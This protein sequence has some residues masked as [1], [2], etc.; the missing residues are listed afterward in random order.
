[1]ALLEKKAKAVQM[2]RDGASYSQIKDALG[3]SKSTLS[4]WLAGMPLPEARLRELRDFNAVRIERYRE[5]RRRTRDARRS[6]V[7][8]VAKREIGALSKR[9]VLIA[10]IFLYW[11]EGTKTDA[12]SVSV[13]N[14]DP[15][16]LRFFIRW[17][18]VLGVPKNKIRFRVHLYKDMN[19]ENEL[20]YWSSALGIPRSQFRKPYVKKSRRSSLSYPQ[21]FGHGTGNVIFGNRDVAER[22]LESLEY[23]RSQF[24][25]DL[26]S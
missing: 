7:R 1:M 16:M 17:L 12:T 11:G 14:T 13:A 22:A 2:R 6:L 5:T 19:I 20:N 10:G 15:A 21:R 9:E 3:V 8:K 18:A 4:T 25:E 26:S 24:A 23:I